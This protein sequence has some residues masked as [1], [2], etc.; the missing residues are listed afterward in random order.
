M[1]NLQP[2][3]RRAHGSWARL[4]VLALVSAVCVGAVA[5]T[6]AGVF[7]DDD[8]PKAD[9]TKPGTKAKKV[10]LD[11]REPITLT[12]LPYVARP[13][14]KFQR[15]DIELPRRDDGP[16]PLVI[17]IHGGAWRSGDKGGDH[18][19]KGLVKKGFAVASINYRLVGNVGWP[20]QIQDCQSAV[21]Y[22]RAN[23]ERFQIDPDRIGVWGASAGGHLAAMLG[24]L[25]DQR[26]SR[27]PPVQAVC[28]FC[29]PADLVNAGADTPPAS[30]NATADM[31][32]G[33]LLGPAAANKKARSIS[34][35]A[36]RKQVLANASPILF[37]SGKEPPF[38]IMHG[39]ADTVVPQVQSVRFASML[40]TKGVNVDFR[41]IAGAGHDLKTRPECQAGAE[42]FFERTLKN[43]AGAGR[44]PAG[45]AKGKAKASEP[46]P[47][48]KPNP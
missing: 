5:W 42:E 48:T 3:G 18:P 35:I 44:Q 46:T 15:F 9:T 37:V 20:A 12:D 45:T 27:S 26:G 10:A 2:D 25:S 38:L 29:G 13:F 11:P 19:A 24:V 23:A 39:T 30:K 7:R 41:S 16:V 21:K 17:W 1:I 32:W 36:A 28:D 8:E 33:L 22:L 43:R 34:P 4:T 40:K 14:G 47:P 31:L 6:D